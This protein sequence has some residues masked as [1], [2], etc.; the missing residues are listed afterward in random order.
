MR[1]FGLGSAL[2][3]LVLWAAGFLGLP[4]AHAAASYFGVTFPD[5]LAGAELV[6]TQNLEKTAPG[7][8]YGVQYRLNDWTIDIY[9]Y[10]FGRASIPDD[11]SSSV[12]RDQAKQAAGDI[13]ELERRGIYGE[14]KL[15]RSYTL[16]D[17]RG[18]DR[19]LCSQYTFVMGTGNV[20]S[21]LC[22]GGSHNKF[23]KFRMTTP[24]HAGSNSE[25][26]R[27]IKAW[28]TILWPE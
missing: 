10:D 22:L 18:R 5:R 25:S 17:H 15:L 27:F 16:P 4:Q 23:V 3:A 24:R 28:S 11:P 9:V 12:L 14:V 13:L 21:V 20:D 26:D 19:L 6:D 7:Q 2:A 1:L 8:G